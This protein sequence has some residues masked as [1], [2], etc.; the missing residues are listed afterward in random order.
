VAEVGKIYFEFD[1]LFWSSDIDKAV[2]AGDPDAE[3]LT[4]WSYPLVFSNWYLFDGEKKHPGFVILT[5]FPLTTK[6]EADASLA[7]DFFKP[8]LETL[9]TDKSKPVP[10]PIRVTS[11]KWS[12]DPFSRGS[13]S[14]YS[15][16]N[17]RKTAV[18]AFEKGIDR[19]R[20]AGEHT[21]MRGATFVHGAYRSGIREAEHVS[22]L[23]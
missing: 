15:I 23:L 10:K 7:Y 3:E 12:V 1:E 22:K 19:I 2:F 14:S 8:V 4:P 20:F 11:S 9:R 6:F 17:D 5:P 18:G 21:T 13:Y 16:G